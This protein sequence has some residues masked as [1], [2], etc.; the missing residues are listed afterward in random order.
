ML[1]HGRRGRVLKVVVP[2]VRDLLHLKDDGADVLDVGDP[3]VNL[4]P[5]LVW[6]DD[7]VDQPHVAGLLGGVLT[8]EHPHF[9]RP[10]LADPGGQHRHVVTVGRTAHAGSGLPK[11]GAGG[12]DGEIAGVSQDVTGADGKSVHGR[13]HR[14]G[15]LLHNLV[16][17]DLGLA[18]VTPVIAVFKLRVVALVVAGA[19]AVGTG[20]VDDHHP[21]AG[22]SGGVQ[23]AVSHLVHG[24]TALGVV[25]LRPV[26]HQPCHTVFLL[27]D[28]VGVRTGAD[29]RAKVI[30]EFLVDHIQGVLES[31]DQFRFCH[32][33]LWAADDLCVVAR[34]LEH[35]GIQPAGKPAGEI[36]YWRAGLVGEINL[37]SG[38]GVIHR[39]AQAS[40]VWPRGRGQTEVETH[41]CHFI[42]RA[43]LQ[44]DTGW[45]KALPNLGK[46]ITGGILTGG[47]NKRSSQMAPGEKWQGTAGQ[48]KRG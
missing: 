6:L 17:A 28:N 40:L 41:A 8:A 29:D 13:N 20:S 7:R 18:A 3:P 45:H 23:Q 35:L 16:V 38:L 33:W 32:I 42:S 43:G 4:G 46:V 15:H 12:G 5:Q 48:E 30:G 39:D 22:V 34:G 31:L 27:V 37:L 26:Q 1:L 19:E 25:G 11:P 24:D 9:P 36:M 2:V 10:F 44:V 47:A 14:L 21:N